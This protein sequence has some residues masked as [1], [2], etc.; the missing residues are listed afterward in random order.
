MRV[1]LLLLFV[2]F[3]SCSPLNVSPTEFLTLNTLRKLPHVHAVDIARA[4]TRPH[5]QIIH[6]LNWPFIERK[7]FLA[8]LQS[9]T[10]QPLSKAES[11]KEWEN[12]LSRVELVQDHQEDLLRALM[13]FHG[14]E[15]VIYLEEPTDLGLDNYQKRAQLLR[16]W[17]DSPGGTQTNSQSVQQ[18]R[19]EALRLGV[20]SR[21]VGLEVYPLEEANLLPSANPTSTRGNKV[22]PDQAALD[23]KESQIVQKVLA[24]ESPVVVLI[25]S[26]RYNLADHVPSDVEV[27]R[28]QVQAHAEAVRE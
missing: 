8:D 5:H 13:R 22:Q 10:E 23:R 25:L 26:S 6:I 27:V 15:K 3:I 2:L 28:V 11:E 20:P 19:E 9:R 14:I 18:H 7:T 1:P 4:E 12:Y 16:D 21:F 17:R 24:G